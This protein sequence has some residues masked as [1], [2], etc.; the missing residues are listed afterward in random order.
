VLV[1]EGRQ[2]FPQLTVR[3]SMVL[4]ATVRR[5]FDPAEIAAM[6]D[7]FPR[8]RPLLDRPAGLLSSGEQQMLALARGLLARPTLLLLDEPSLGLAPSVAQEL[9]DAL[10]R[11][12]DDGLSLVPVDQMADLALPLADR[13]AL[14]GHGRIGGIGTPAEMAASLDYFAAKAS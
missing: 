3:E 9:F 10:S 2:V 12:R 7:R 6:L 8:L 11:L 5:N 14:L 4:G 13:A 1:P